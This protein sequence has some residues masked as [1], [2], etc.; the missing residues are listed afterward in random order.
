MRLSIYIL[1]AQVLLFYIIAD[2]SSSHAAMIQLATFN[3]VLHLINVGYGIVG[4][5]DRYTLTV[6]IHQSLLA[7]GPNLIYAL[8]Y[9]YR[10]TESHRVFFRANA[11]LTLVEFLFAFTQAEGIIDRKKIICSD[12]RN[13][14][15][16]NQRR[17]LLFTIL[18][19]I[20]GILLALVNVIIWCIDKSRNRFKKGKSIQEYEQL[21][22]NWMMWK[23]KEWSRARIIVGFVATLIWVYSVV[24]L[25][26]FISDFH[27]QMRQFPDISSNE[28][29]WSYGQLMPFCCSI[30]GLFYA[31]RKLLI[32]KGSQAY[33]FLRIS[34]DV[35]QV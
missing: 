20:V 33:K 34:S 18:P 27:I 11:I 2:H 26:Y 32:E 14:L 12:L 35:I 28:N 23:A 17:R 5:L 25:E 16:N 6:L 1:T 3:L 19:F 24:N 9:S 15:R 21:R 4:L 13:A 30:V 29:G 7:T 8:K 22:P 31:F 10:H